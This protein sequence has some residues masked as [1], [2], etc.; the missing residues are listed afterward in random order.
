MMSLKHNFLFDLS[1]YLMQDWGPGLKSSCISLTATSIHL[2][3]TLCL[4]HI[5]LLP[6]ESVSLS[7]SL[8]TPYPLSRPLSL[9]DA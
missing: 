5:S 8:S 2:S 1:V 3:S 9:P 4:D 6:P 7:L